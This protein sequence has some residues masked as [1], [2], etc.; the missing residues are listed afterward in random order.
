MARITLETN[1]TLTMRQLG[2]DDA[3][4]IYP[5]IKSEDNF[6]Q[7]LDRQIGCN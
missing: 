3:K 4:D 6:F 7:K 1:G 5:V 2:L